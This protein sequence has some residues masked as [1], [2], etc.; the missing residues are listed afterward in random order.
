MKL[1]ET[2]E[3]EFMDLE[4]WVEET[5]S[6]DVKFKKLLAIKQN[7]KYEATTYVTEEGLKTVTK[8]YEL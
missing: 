2:L 1:I 4:T 5:S 8:I 6:F 7:Y 3:R